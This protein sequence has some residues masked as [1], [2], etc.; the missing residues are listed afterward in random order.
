[1][2]GKGG[3][4]DQEAEHSRIFPWWIGRSIHY[5]SS[6]FEGVVREDPACSK[7]SP[8]SWFSKEFLT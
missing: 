6:L 1:M 2:A 8:A 7:S 5:W 3:K 4:G